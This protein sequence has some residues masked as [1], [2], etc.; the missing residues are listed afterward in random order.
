MGHVSIFKDAPSKTHG[1]PS[2]SLHRQGFSCCYKR[3]APCAVVPTFHLLALLFT[4]FSLLQQR[5]LRLPTHGTV[6]LSLMLNRLLPLVPRPQQMRR[7][8]RWDRVSNARFARLSFHI[9][10]AVSCCWLISSCLT[11]PSALAPPHPALCTARC[12]LA[13]INLFPCVLDC[14]LEPPID[15]TSMPCCCCRPSEDCGEA[16]TCR[17]DISAAGGDWRRSCCC[18]TLNK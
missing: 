18:R 13:L 11:C 5:L 12:S 10:P 14:E 17:C 15:K 4:R 2:W 8:C 7:N 1:L 9:S 6:V 3:V 16:E